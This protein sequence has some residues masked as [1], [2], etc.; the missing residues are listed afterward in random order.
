MTRFLFFLL[1]SLLSFASPVNVSAQESA[2]SD[3]IIVRLSTEQQLMPLFLAK[4]IDQNAGL[5]R[6]YLDQLESVLR[7]DLGHNGMTQVL[8]HNK[9]RALLVDTGTLDDLGRPEE[10]QAQNIFYVVKI[11]AK[12]KKLFVRVLSVNS[13]M[14]KRIDGL[15]LSGDALQD[16]S[17]IHLL[18][19]TIHK[20]LFGTD[21]IASTHI[22]YTLKTKSGDDSNKWLSDIWEA[23]Y[24]GANA[25]RLSQE[26]SG[27]CVTPVYVPP[28]PGHVSASIFYVSYK[29]GQPKIYI[30]ALKDGIGRRFSYLKANQLMPAISRGRDKVAFISDVTGNPDLFLQDFSVESGAVGKPRQIYTTHQATQGSPTFSPDG[31]QIAFVSNKDGSPRIYIMDIP[32]PETKLKDIKARLISKANRESSAPC[33]S[34]DGSKIAY[35]ARSGGDRQIWVYDLE[36]DEERQITQGTGNKENPSWAPNSLHLI[37][38]SSNADACELYIVNL[39]QPQAVKITNGSGEKRFPAWEPR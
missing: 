5:D 31:K 6:A 4:F 32:S 27:Y 25:R 23:D 29:N 14:I 16:R 26:G 36:R 37:F 33:W 12:D 2:D 21:G 35:C 9:A 10:W 19:D 24:D 15:P 7:F 8:S 30:A 34:P 28:K 3:P 17:Q 39:N 22:V 1:A 11:W 13:N 38:N 20:A 18:A